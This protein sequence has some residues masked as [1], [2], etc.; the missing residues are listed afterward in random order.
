MTPTEPVRRALENAARLLGVTPAALQQAMEKKKVQS[1]E[2]FMGV[3][4]AEK[5][6]DSRS[7]LSKAIYGRMFDWLVQRVN[8]AME[9]D[10]QSSSNIIG[11]CTVGVYKEGCGLD[12]EREREREREGERE[13]S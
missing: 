2:V 9:G 13:S 4:S 1:K 11:V 3:L 6:A 7:C 12:R 5:A 10:L 8:R